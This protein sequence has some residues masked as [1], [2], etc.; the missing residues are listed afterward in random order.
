VNLLRR[1]RRHPARS[2]TA[3]VNLAKLATLSPGRRGIAGCSSSWTS[4]RGEAPQSL[5]AG[6]LPLAALP[7]DLGREAELPVPLSLTLWGAG[8][9]RAPQ[10]DPRSEAGT[11]GR[12]T[13]RGQAHGNTHWVRLRPPEFEDSANRRVM[14]KAESP[15]QPAIGRLVPCHDEGR[16]VGLG[17]PPQ[18]CVTLGGAPPSRLGVRRQCASLRR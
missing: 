18:E 15:G 17:H 5:N 1:P 8:R 10:L 12:A 16:A 11:L 3:V 2:S 7:P 13:S 9:F 4:R 14:V 6:A